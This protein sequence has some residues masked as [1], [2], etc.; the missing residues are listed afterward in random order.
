[1]RLVQEGT[2]VPTMEL[3]TAVGGAERSAEAEAVDVGASRADFVRR[4]SRRTVPSYTH[5]FY[6]FLSSVSSH[7]CMF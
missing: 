7:L 2:H 4:R 1:M 5:P 6:F 3:A